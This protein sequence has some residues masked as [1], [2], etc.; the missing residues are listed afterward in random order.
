M[1][2]PVYDAGMKVRREVLGDE[3][4]DRAIERTHRVHG[5]VSGLHHPLR[6]GRACGRARGWTAARAA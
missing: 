4:V 6:V 3:H 5:A 2:D 1:S